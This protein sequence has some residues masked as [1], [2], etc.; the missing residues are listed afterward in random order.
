MAT[1]FKVKPTHKAVKNYYAE[2]ATYAD[3]SVEHEGT[4]L[5]HSLEKSE[6]H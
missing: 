6:Q 5:Q 2:L 1:A 4:L 3:Q